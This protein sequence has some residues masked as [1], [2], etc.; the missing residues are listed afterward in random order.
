MALFSDGPIS[1]VDDLVQHD[2]SL[3]SVASTEGIDVTAKLTLAHTE[4]GI[5]LDALFGREASIYSSGSGGA[6]LD[7]AHLA[8]SPSLK[9]WH[10]FR[11]LELV[12]RDAYFN[13]L[14]ERYK[15]KWSEY[16]SLARWAMGKFIEIGAGLINDPLSQPGEPMISL[17]SSSQAGGTL[18]VSVTVLNSAGEE[19]TPSVAIEI[20]VPDGSV[21]LLQLGARPSN[22]ISWNI[23]G[24]V[25]PSKMTLQTSVPLP[26]TA[27]WEYV[28]PGSISGRGPGMGQTW[29]FIRDLP[30]RIM[31]G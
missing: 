12:Y 19:S 8:V 17:E 20:A 25:S 11:T 18:Y 31:R 10:I 24:G 30:R 16:Q 9:S 13:L 28:L 3:I 7:S 29:N 27:S 6:L 23:Y 5:E 14:N 4:M 2:S 21:S 15:G 1:T 22:A 26:T